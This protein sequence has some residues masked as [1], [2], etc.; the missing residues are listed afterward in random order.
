MNN[1]DQMLNIADVSYYIETYLIKR[2]ENVDLESRNYKL[3]SNE[4]KDMNE[5]FIKNQGR[6]I[7]LPPNTEFIGGKYDPNTGTTVTL[8]KDTKTGEIKAGCA[9]TNFNA[10]GEEKDK[11]VGNWFDIAYYGIGVDG[12]EVQFVL[13]YF[14]E[15]NIY[16]TEITGHSLGGCIAQITGLKLQIDVTVFNSAPLSNDMSTSVIDNLIKVG[17]EVVDALDFSFSQTQLEMLDEY[18]AQLEIQHQ[19]LVDNIRSLE[20]LLKNYKGKYYNYVTDYDILT[21]VNNTFD[22]TLIGDPTVVFNDT[23]EKDSDYATTGIMAGGVVAFI[24]NP[25]AGVVTGVS[26]TMVLKMTNAHLTSAYLKH[27]GFG[28]E[29]IEILNILNDYVVNDEIKIDI[30]GDGIIDVDY[31]QDDF[32]AHNLFVDHGAGYNSTNQIIVDEEGLKNFANNLRYMA[33]NEVNEIINI[34][35]VALTKNEQISCNKEFRINKT[36]ENIKEHVKESILSGFIDILENK[37]LEVRQEHPDTLSLMQSIKD[38][39]ENNSDDFVKTKYKFKT[40]LNEKLD[41]FIYGLQTINNVYNP[42][43][44]DNDLDNRLQTLKSILDETLAE[45][46]SDILKDTNDSEIKDAL[47]SKFDEEFNKLNEVSN[48]I[49]KE[50]IQVGEIADEIA[51]NFT[52]LDENLSKKISGQYSFDEFVN[53]NKEEFNVSYVTEISPNVTLENQIDNGIDMMKE[54]II[55]SLNKQLDGIKEDLYSI[56]CGRCQLE[57]YKDD[58][59][60]DL[61]TATMITKDDVIVYYNVDNTTPNEKSICFIDYLSEAEKNLVNNL[62]TKFEVYDQICVL[63]HTLDLFIYTDG[64]IENYLRT[65]L[66]ELLYEEGNFDEQMATLVIVSNKYNTIKEELEMARVAIENSSDSLALT[67][68]NKYI[69]DLINKIQFFIDSVEFLT[70]Q[71]PVIR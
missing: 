38:K 31:N 69:E 37:L 59:K 48:Y 63:Y 56:D 8:F 39:L 6:E 22:S 68:L 36:K 52:K 57:M 1:M 21:F 34:C 28:I 62:D 32:K 49:Y 17:G 40:K 46:L 24:F 23:N 47:V 16:P 43:Y 55:K 9:G 3:D 70:A 41:E 66:F 33:E 64:N 35:N 25:V 67:E 7:E 30:N 65:R 54:T 50:L 26:T 42:N 12:P 20:E 19:G 18:K 61:I 45:V 27:E 15:M 51:I 60:N 13:D 10:G 53:I 29:Q 14:K 44:Q 5:W 71:V 58:V 4:W 2:N 11:D